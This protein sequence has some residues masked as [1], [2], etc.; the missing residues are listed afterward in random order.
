MIKKIT[1][2]IKELGIE[3]RYVALD[4][5]GFFGCFNSKPIIM[6]NAQLDVITTAVTLLHEVAHFLNGDYDKAIS[7]RLQNNN[8]EYE[9]NR[10]MIQKVL[11]L[12]DQEH[13]F[14]P[15]TNYYQILHSL[16]LP[17]HLNTVV[18]DELA[19]L[20]Q[21]K[22]GIDDDKAA[23]QYY[24]SAQESANYISNYRKVA[25]MTKNY[26]KMPIDD[27]LSF[28]FPEFRMAKELYTLI[29]SDRAH[30]GEFL[31]FVEVSKDHTSQEAYFKLKLS[32]M[33]NQTDALY[34]LALDDKLIGCVDLHGIDLLANKAEIGYWLHSSYANQGIMSKAI[35][36][37]CTYAFHNLGLNRL[38]IVADVANTAS[39]Q[40]ALKNGFTF[41]GTEKEVAIKSGNYRDHNHYYLL[42]RDFMAASLDK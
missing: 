17:S 6:V 22:Y 20:I 1:R 34:V 28:L 30:I 33:A 9:A 4:S 21:D 13:D 7:N 41:V 23:Y 40:V 36:Q 32:G 11:F 2:Q 3:V 18:Y 12:L 39:N 31:D 37:L 15:H 10:F 19:K 27:R 24:Q 35:Y 26:F 5:N 38:A 16:A 8:M 42:K 14:T 25:P 29:D